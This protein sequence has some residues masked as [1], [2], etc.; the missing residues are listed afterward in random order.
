MKG[1]TTLEFSGS[2]L[3]FLAVLVAV[4][5]VTLSDI[6][7]F[8]TYAGT[9]E[10]N[11]EAKKTTDLILNSE[12]RHSNGSGGTDWENHPEDTEMLGLASEEMRID[13]SKL[14]MLE[15]AEPGHYNY[16]NMV[17]DLGLEHRYSFNFTWHPVVETHRNF[18]RGD[19]P[20]DPDIDEPN[21]GYYSNAQ[22]RIHY[23]E[24]T[25]EGQDIRFLMAA[26]D[27]SYNTTYVT[28]FDWDFSADPKTEGDTFTAGGRTFTIE[29]I[30]NRDR[31][32]GASIVLSSH[33][34]HV[35]RSPDAAEGTRAKLNRYPLMEDSSS[36]TDVVKM[37]VLTW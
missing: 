5:T 23:G 6:P 33:L 35:G 8:N 15:T 7:Q 19:P 22:N 29:K 10:K 28:T 9:T 27:G 21:S 2:F 30:Q 32:P 36:S 37:E 18:V 12:G 34:K 24:T 1:Q 3:F 16:S 26:F 14:A 11:L 13:R 31:R 20:S 25:L 17:E 4:L